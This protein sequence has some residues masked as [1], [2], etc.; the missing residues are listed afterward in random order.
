MAQSVR[1]RRPVGSPL[2]PAEE[3]EKVSP[4]DQTNPTVE[5]QRGL[6]TG[7]PGLPWTEPVRRVVQVVC[8]EC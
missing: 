8:G 4:A 2:L 7:A 1:D 6:A 5:V 3:A